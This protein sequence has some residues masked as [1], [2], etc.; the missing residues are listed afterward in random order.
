VFQQFNLIPT[1]RGTTM[2]LLPWFARAVREKRVAPRE[3]L[4]TQV[5][6]SIALA[7][8]FAPLGRRTTAGG[9]CPSPGQSARS[10]HRRRADRKP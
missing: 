8:S 4:M 5:G 10:D 7:S 2:S 1:W 3:S 9:H 6:W